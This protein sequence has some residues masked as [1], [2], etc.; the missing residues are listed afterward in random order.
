MMDF[1]DF[2]QKAEQDIRA[3]L[4]DASPGIEVRINQV[5]KLQEESYTA[6]TL[7]PA[8]SNIG[9]NLN[10][11]QLYDYLQRG[12]SCEA[13]ISSAVNQA[14]E[15]LASMPRF[16]ISELSS[17][18]AAK[19]L[20]FVDVVGTK[21]NAEMLSKVPHTDMKEWDQKYHEQENAEIHEM[22]HAARLTP[23]Q[24]AEVLR[25]LQ[26]SAPDMTQL[27]N[28]EDRNDEN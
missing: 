19:D 7:T 21:V 1:K 23:E 10:L 24:L 11:N 2:T 13:V 18:E 14:K 28:E 15:H 22:V 4:E 6:I 5:E 17:Y 20:L 12:E 9:M 16:N 26:H 25:R 8:G 3:A 27:N